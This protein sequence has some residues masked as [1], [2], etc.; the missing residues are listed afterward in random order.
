MGRAR[1]TASHLLATLA[2]VTHESHR[3]D[4][5]KRPALPKGAVPRL[6]FLSNGTRTLV[7]RAGETLLL[8]SVVGLMGGTV[9]FAFAGPASAQ[10]SGKN[11]PATATQA[12]KALTV[13]LSGS[14]KWSTGLDPATST[15]ATGE[16]G[17]AIYGQLFS[18]TPT[19]KIVP[20][21]ASGYS[22]SNAGR[23][24]TLKIRDGVKFSDGTP[25]DAQAVAFN[26]KRDLEPQNA[27]TCAANFPVAGI[28]TPDGRTVVIQLTEP[29]APFIEGFIGASPNAIVSPTALSRLGEQAFRVTPVGAGPFVVVSDAIDSKVVLKRNPS[30]WQKGKPRLDS[31]TFSLVGS[32]ASE[33]DAMTTGEG[34]VAFGVNTLPL[35]QQARKQFNVHEVTTETEILQINTTVPPFNNQL[36]REA[37][38]YATDSKGLMKGFFGTTKYYDESIDGPGGYFY[39]KQ[40]PGYRSYNLAKAKSIVKQL[41]GLQFKLTEL[42]YESGFLGAQLA[43]ALQAQWARAGIKATIAPVNDLSILVKD[44]RTNTWQVAPESTGGLDPSLAPGL[45]WR[46]ASNG[47]F[48]G[49]KDPNVDSL[50]QKGVSTVN[51]GAR[52]KIYRDLWAYMARQA[53][54]LVLFADP[55]PI[56]GWTLINR[57]VSGSSLNSNNVPAIDWGEI[58]LK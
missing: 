2:S 17:A 13:L 12:K 28:S 21:L 39:E 4:I 27:C 10:A 41:G 18:E 5:L 15:S 24:W 43:T 16:I 9:S 42:G 35:V 54:A 33:Y 20:S 8:T 56:Q 7:R 51:L 14:L 57:K 11:V 34:Q 40:V 48:T 44:F 30:Y 58:G 45:V 22:E 3:R 32:D 38:F 25:F 6:S 49:V 53:Y 36:A 1:M 31:L 37:L 26:I 50:I 55:A 23:T 19:G 29:F 47:P 52:D 46:F